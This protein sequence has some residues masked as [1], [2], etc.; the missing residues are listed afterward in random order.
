MRIQD[1]K[2]ERYFA[3]YEFSAPYLLC[4]SDCESLRAADLLAMDPGA[5]EAFQDLWLGYTESRGNP[6]LRGEI[7]KLYEGI[8][9]EQVL[10]HSGAEEA[11]FVAMNVLLQKGDHVI[12]QSPCYQSLAEVARAIGC[13][14]TSWEARE[15]SGWALDPDDLKKLL[16]PETRLVVVNCPHN[17]TGYT[18]TREVFDEL[19]RLSRHYG[20]TVFSDEVYRFLEYDER[21]RLPA[22][23]EMDGKGISV[24]VMSKAFGLAGLR[25]GW[26][27]TRDPALFERLAAFKDFTTI[28]NSAPSEF[29]STVAL[30]HRD[31]ILQRNL[32][33][34]LKNLSVLDRF[35]SRFSE[36]FCWRRPKAGPVAFPSL[37]AG[38]AEE[39]CRDLV[40]KAGVLLLPGTVYD[41]GP[42]HF[43]I[44]FG[45][46]T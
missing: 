37:R 24:G 13:D 23:C 30:K 22:W 9:P 33:I 18:M 3:E 15:S 25:I 7:A 21:D 14:V 6:T 12:V 36:R 41:A 26:S 32:D 27:V 46:R 34:V 5:G 16:R 10:V 31:R 42:S 2:L 38:N 39:F 40:E 17:P 35:F 8:E 20:F 44:G 45:G 28:C 19:A 1:F 29:L 4:C 11:I 43:R